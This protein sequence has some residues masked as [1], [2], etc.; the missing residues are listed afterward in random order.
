MNGTVPGATK[1]M[2]LS[3]DLVPVG[4]AIVGLEASPSGVDPTGSALHAA[5]ITAFVDADDQLGN[6]K[7]GAARVSRQ[8]EFLGG[9]WCARECLR[10]HA[11][12]AADTPI[13]VGPH[14]E[15]LWPDGI[16][17]SIAHASPYVLA[18]TAFRGTAQSIG[19]DVAPWL[20]DG[21]TDRIGANIAMPGE[22]NS[23]INSN[24][25]SMARRLTLVFSA[26]K[27]IY[28]A[29]YP[30]VQCPFGLD[31]ARLSR[32][33]PDGATSG[34]FEAHLTMALKNLPSQMPLVGRYQCRQDA[35]ITTLVCLSRGV[36]AFHCTTAAT[37]V[38]P[39]VIRSVSHGRGDDQ[40]HAHTTS[41]KKGPVCPRNRKSLSMTRVPITVRS[42]RCGSSMAICVTWRWWAHEHL[43]S[44]YLSHHA[45]R[46][47][48]ASCNRRPGPPRVRLR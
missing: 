20:D 28:K 5:M 12:E 45:C 16:V 43:A 46:D 21:A 33:V 19:L 11:P 6:A 15:P 27:S 23:L 39:W 36:R 29:L 31:H 44:T 2:A 38:A 32:I 48:G 9:R 30:L 35:I 14:R 1:R 18:A 40:T 10:E 41:N 26:K 8:S 3:P 42:N 22:L 34:R 47:A 25:W 17:G 13:G 4:V 24:G 7:L 37:A